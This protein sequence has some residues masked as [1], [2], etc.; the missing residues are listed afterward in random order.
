MLFYYI[1]VDPLFFACVATRMMRLV[2]LSRKV[3][4]IATY[5]C[6]IFLKRKQNKKEKA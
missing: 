5:F 4:G 6:F 2:F 1:F 3:F